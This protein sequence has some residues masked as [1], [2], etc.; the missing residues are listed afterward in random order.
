MENRL[1]SD[2]LLSY[3]LDLATGEWCE[4]AWDAYLGGL[5]FQFNSLSD[6]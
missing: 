5:K 1:N 2:V 4:Q 3:D 6:E